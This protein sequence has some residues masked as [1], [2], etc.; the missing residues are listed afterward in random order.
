MRETRRIMVQWQGGDYLYLTYAP[1]H[2]KD[3]FVAL[4]EEFPNYSS[5]KIFEIRC[6]LMTMKFN[7][8]GRISKHL[9]ALESRFIDLESTGVKMT[10]VE[11][12]TILIC[13]LPNHI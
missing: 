7:G 5:M 6:D 13:G 12:V 8:R 4:E 2:P 9:D 1:R 3:I 11:K 10:D